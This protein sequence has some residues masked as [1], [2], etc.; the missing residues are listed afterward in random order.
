MVNLKS[1]LTAVISWLVGGIIMVDHVD[2]PGDFK[3]MGHCENNQDFKIMADRETES[4]PA[5]IA[6]Q[7]F[8]QHTRLA[9]TLTS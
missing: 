5:R 2:N 9:F 1:H 8:R 7:R 4:N 6:Q 3:I